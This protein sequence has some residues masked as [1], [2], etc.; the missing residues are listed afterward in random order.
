MNH[1]Y[2]GCRN[3]KPF[4]PAATCSELR[5]G[6]REDRLFEFGLFEFLSNTGVLPPFRLCAQRIAN[7]LQAGLS[8]FNREAAVAKWSGL[9]FEVGGFQVG[10]PISMKIRHV[11]GLLH[12][13]S[14]VVK[15]PPVNVVR[16]YGYGWQLRCR[17]PHLT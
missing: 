2:Q 6:S 10:I 11:L 7:N 8:D 3:D 12:A 5:S 17:P 15:H 4:L 1:E 9:G 16:K 13:K 14:Y